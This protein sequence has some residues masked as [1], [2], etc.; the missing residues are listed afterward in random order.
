MRLAVEQ[1]NAVFHAV[2]L[3]NA[4][5]MSADCCAETVQHAWRA[6]C[7]L[8][9]FGRVADQEIYKVKMDAVTTRH[10]AAS[11]VCFPADM[12]S[13]HVTNCLHLSVQLYLCLCTSIPVLFPV[14]LH[15][16]RAA[17]CFTMC[18]STLG[19]CLSCVHAHLYLSIG[20]PFLIRHRGCAA[21]IARLLSWHILLVD[22]LLP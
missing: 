6:Y 19:L 2:T 7:P 11:Q 20:S 1:C 5:Y 9:C 13:V 12:V 16:S 15:G 3:C 10:L 22:S 17:C 18:V 4:A 21:W 14:V 8:L